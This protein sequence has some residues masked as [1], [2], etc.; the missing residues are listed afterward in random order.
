MANNYNVDPRTRP[1]YSWYKGEH[2][3]YALCF[4]DQDGESCF[5][6][7]NMDDFTKTDSL[8]THFFEAAFKYLT[9]NKK[10]LSQAERAR[11]AW[12]MACNMRTLYHMLSKNTDTPEKFIFWPCE[13]QPTSD[14]SRILNPDDVED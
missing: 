11:T 10:H 12:E 14:K 7:Y 4:Y 3:R 13:Q 2:S 5:I 8:N 9:E 1:Y 6:V